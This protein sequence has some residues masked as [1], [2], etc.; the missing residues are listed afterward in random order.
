MANFYG[1]DTF[2]DID[3]ANDG[4]RTIEIT[5]HEFRFLLDFYA[6]HKAVQMIRDA[7]T[8]YNESR[9]NKAIEEKGN[10]NA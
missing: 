9:D 2:V 8:A 4:E 1:E 7:E 10:D 5:L 3:V 6:T